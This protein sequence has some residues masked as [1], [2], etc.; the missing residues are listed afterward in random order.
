[1]HK[2]DVTELS[3]GDD[4]IQWDELVDISSQGT[5]FHKTGWLDACARSLGKKVKIFGCF[6]DGQLI[7]GCPLFLEKKYS[8]VPYAV[9]TCPMTPYGGFVLS[10][11][12][13]TGVHKQ[14]SFSRQIIESLIREIKKEHFFSVSILNSPEFLDI[15]PFTWNGWRSHVY[16]AYYINLKNN[17][18]S[19]IDT[20]V[21]KIIRKAEDQQFILEP[22]SDISRYY[23]L[24]SSTYTRK[25]IKPP[26]SKQLITELYS[27]IMNQKCGELVVARTPDD[28]IISAEFVV[29]DTRRAYR[30]SPASDALF[31]DSGAPS[32]VL[33]TTLKRMQDRGI[34]TMNLMAANTPQLSMFISRFNPA[35]VPYYQVQSWIYDDILKH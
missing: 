4:L 20:R 2:F 12:P 13:G 28:K 21:K 6:H 35:L 1:M 18:E 14:E 31:L 5:I 33:F 19:H 26:A 32:L 3:R 29:W 11:S 34:P 30:W 7:G 22:S 17:L 10:K 27:F 25:K 23:D 9:S 8:V 15:R 24:F 16:Y